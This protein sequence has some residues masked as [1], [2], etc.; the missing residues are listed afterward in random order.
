MRP[1]KL[2]TYL[3]SVILT[4]SAVA[5]PP[6]GRPGQRPGPGPGGFG[7]GQFRM[8]N[9]LLDAV[10]KDKNGE[11]SPEEIENAAV[12]LKSLDK[13][14][15]GKLDAMEMRP[16][17]EGM[18]PGGFGGGFGGS[19][20]GNPQEMVDRLMEMDA[21]KDGKLG[22]DELPE[23]L[24]AMLTRGDK[25]EDGVLDKEEILASARGGFGGPGGPGGPGGDFV[26]QMLQRADADKDGK[27]T[28]DEI[29]PFMKNQLDQMDTN[30]DDALDKA[31]LEAFSARMRNSRGGEGP[32]GGEGRRPS[33]PA[34]EEDDSKEKQKEEPKEESKPN[35]P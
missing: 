11:L 17:F 31:E 21:N 10:D 34:A 20:G 14:S 8:P 24:Q 5:Q 16:N 19:G 4:A 13:N 28:G 27:L 7:G 6:E 2:A 3:A 15:D 33:R 1:I 30:K 26:A 35:A 12:A 23:R 18:P 29:P 9:P 25:N 32:R 22:K